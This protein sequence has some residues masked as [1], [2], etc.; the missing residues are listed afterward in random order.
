MKAEETDAYISG[1]PSVVDESTRELA[2]RYIN[3]SDAIALV[4]E[5]GNEPIACILG[6]IASSS[7]PP[8][9]V[10]RVGHIAVCWVEPEHRNSGIAARLVNHAEN[11]FREREVS[12]VELSYMAKN[13]LAAVA[14]Q[15]LGYEPFR[16]FAHKQL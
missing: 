9:N 11:W 8:A 10:G 2:A 15:R 16:V 12:L 7:F 13:R 6:E 14:W 1:L 5:A 3:N 4:A